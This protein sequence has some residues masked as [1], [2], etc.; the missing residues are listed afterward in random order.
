LH[1]AL[2]RAGKADEAIILKNQLDLAAA[3]ADVD[4]SVSCY[5][6]NAGAANGTCCK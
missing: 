6:R 3:S 5:C 4:V 1:E 2:T